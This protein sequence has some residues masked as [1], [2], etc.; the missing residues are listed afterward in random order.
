MA[1]RVVVIM[2]GLELAD[3]VNVYSTNLTVFH[4][5]SVNGGLHA[6]VKGLKTKNHAN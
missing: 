3:S 4:Y 5:F 2:A 1:F 6:D